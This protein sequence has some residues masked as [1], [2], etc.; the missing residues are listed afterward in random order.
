MRETEHDSV[1]DRSAR[2]GGYTA[3]VGSNVRPAEGN[4]STRPPA[5]PRG[6][7]PSL[8]EDQ[9]IDAALQIIR[10]EGLDALSMR[11]LSQQL[12]R[13]QM[14]A[15]SYVADKQQLLD[16][17]AR[18]TLAEVRIPGPDDGAWDDQLRLLID[19][20]D[21]QLRRHPG[22]AGLLLQRMLHSDRRLVYALMAIMVEAGLHE[23]QVLLAYSTI[24]TYL[25]GRYQVALADVPA[26]EADT[27]P[28]LTHVMSFLDELHR[29]DYYNFGIDILLDGLRARVAENLREQ[30][31][32]HT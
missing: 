25:F 13:S 18:R 8:T 1:P 23:K 14:A 28:A 26:D 3:P 31:G 11:R 21:T 17:V 20:I 19:R 2:T 6:R 27:P 22:I 15:Y 16:L 32:R 29:A 9:I 10:T 7:P 4:G 12:G 30:A 24:H 5:R